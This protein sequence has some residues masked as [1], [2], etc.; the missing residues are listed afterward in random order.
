MKIIQ[1]KINRITIMEISTREEIH[2][3]V[4]ESRAKGFHV[5]AFEKRKDGYYLNMFKESPMEEI[6]EEELKEM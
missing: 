1:T 5:Q 3:F 2:K 4:D 6:S